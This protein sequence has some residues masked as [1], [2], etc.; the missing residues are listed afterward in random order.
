MPR[1]V[2]VIMTSIAM[3]I[4][5]MIIMAVM[6]RFQVCQ[7]IQLE[8]CHQSYMRIGNASQVFGSRLHVELLQHSVT[9]SVGTFLGNHG[10]DIFDIAKQSLIGAPSIP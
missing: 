1:M 3:I 8:T 2:L 10:V 7:V 5:P 9:A 6:R 4:M